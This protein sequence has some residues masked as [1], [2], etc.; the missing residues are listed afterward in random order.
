MKTFKRISALLLALMMALTLFGCDGGKSKDD[1][2]DKKS[3]KSSSSS[4]EGAVKK[5]FKAIEETDVDT[6][7]DLM[8]STQKHFYKKYYSNTIE[9]Q[10][11][12]ELEQYLEDMEAYYGEDLKLT[13]SDMEVTDMTEDELEEIKDDYAR[14]GG[15]EENV[16]DGVKIEFD[17]DA[18]G[19]KGEGNG[20]GEANVI[21]EDGKWKIG[22]MDWDF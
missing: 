22:Y 18:E 10:A 7:I 14:N 2:D 3:K 11:E 21:K 1:D 15:G 5:Y 19:D 8:P 4:A 16:E 13:V 17:L 12:S 20:H 9:T 6:Y